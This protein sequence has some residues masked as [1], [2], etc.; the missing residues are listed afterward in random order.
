[1]LQVCRYKLPY[2]TFI[3]GWIMLIFF[4]KCS[5]ISLVIR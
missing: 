3:T 1:M 5:Y 2:V 4:K